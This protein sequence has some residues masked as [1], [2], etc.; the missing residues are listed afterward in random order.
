MKIC[1]ILT[2]FNQTVNLTFTKNRK[3]SK[4]SQQKHICYL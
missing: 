2:N 3:Y 1:I 4:Q